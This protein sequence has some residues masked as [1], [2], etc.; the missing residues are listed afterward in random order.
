VVRKAVAI[1]REHGLATFIRG[2][3]R[4]SLLL[5]ESKTGHMECLHL[6]KMN[7]DFLPET[8][9]PRS[10]HVRTFQEGDKESWTR[11]MD[12]VF[13]QEYKF[14]NHQIG[15][16]VGNREFDPGS[17]VFVEREGRPVGTASAL[18]TEHEGEPAG[19]VHMVGVV[20]EHRGKG[21]GRLLVLRVLHYFMEKGYTE[22]Y[23]DTQ[24]HRVSAI[25]LY[26]SLGFEPVEMKPL[27]G[28][29]DT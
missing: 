23:L 27:H 5:F 17:I 1:I 6:Q 3:L 28:Q 25:K 21:L 24:H 20:A 19:F 11:I 12:R 4:R 18:I 22:V 16:L 26:R 29:D 14:W 7:L 2:S 15:E 8:V 10:Y 9:V 13:G